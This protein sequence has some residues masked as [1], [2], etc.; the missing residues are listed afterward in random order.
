[1]ALW[2]KATRAA[3]RTGAVFGLSS[4]LH[5]PVETAAFRREQPV[6]EI[7]L[8]ILAN[9]SKILIMR[10]TT[11]T[12]QQ[13]NIRVSPDLYEQAKGKA[14]AGERSLAQYVR[15]LILQDLERG[16]DDS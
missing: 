6:R 7:P 14:K 10:H 2:L 9:A 11:R 13:I 5:Q 1:M 15:Y 8:A 4:S 16:G 3:M 12:Y